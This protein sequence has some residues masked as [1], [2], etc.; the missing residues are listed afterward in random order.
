MPAGADTGLLVNLTLPG[1]YKKN[2]PVSI[3]LRM[4]T[5]AGSCAIEFAPSAVYRFRNNALL[6]VQLATGGG[7][8]QQGPATYLVSTA[9]GLVHTRKFK[10]Q[11]A[12]AGTILDQRAGDN[13]VLM[14]HRKGTSGQDT[15]ANDL[16]ATQ[17]RITYTAN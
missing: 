11:K 15:C 13:I 16:T 17:A 6:A 1:N 2:S 7:L 3:A 8:S 4:L 9:G 12:A 5:E 10:L 14:F